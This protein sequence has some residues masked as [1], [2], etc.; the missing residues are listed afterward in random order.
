MS[1]VAAPD[2]ALRRVQRELNAHGFLY[3]V[4]DRWSAAVYVCQKLRPIA[5]VL[6]GAASCDDDKVSAAQL[7]EHAA[8]RVG[9]HLK[10][11][12]RVERTH[13]DDESV[14][15]RVEALRTGGGRVVFLGG[16]IAFRFA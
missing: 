10:H 8:G 5:A 2:R 14:V 16:P 12:W 6:N 9:G 4:H 11:R 15:G 1:I 3:L 13:V 7:Y